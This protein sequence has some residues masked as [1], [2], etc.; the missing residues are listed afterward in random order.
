MPEGTLA[1]P[2][3]LR[4]AR[5]AICINTVNLLVAGLIVPQSGKA[6]QKVGIA[7]VFDPNV[8]SR[9]QHSRGST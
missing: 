6:R 3:R 2:T 7:V 5:R 8:H 1:R 9:Q 4:I